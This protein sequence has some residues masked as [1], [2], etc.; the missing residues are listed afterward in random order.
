MERLTGTDPNDPDTDGDGIGDWVE[1]IRGTNPTARI[2]GGSGDA[3]TTS[4]T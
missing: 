4:M 1:G 2:T 3:T